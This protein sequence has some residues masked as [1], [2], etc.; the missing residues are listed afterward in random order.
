MD[1]SSQIALAFPRGAHQEAL[2]E[3]VFRYVGEHGLAWT[4]AV[5]PESLSLS[6]TDLVDW[7]GDGVLAAIDT[8]EQAEVA[9]SLTMPVVNISSSLPESPSPR[10]MVDNR[11]VGQVAAEHLLAKGQTA[12][13]FYGLEG[14]EYSK[15]RWKGFEARLEEA[16]V[17]GTQHLAAP[18]YSF[19]GDRWKQQLDEL[20]AW[21]TTLPQP[22]GVFAVSDY[23]SRLVLDAA[24]QAG[25][26]SPRQLAI[27]GVDNE[28]IICE[29]C[30]P[31]LSSVV[32]NNTLEGY[33]AA[34]M[35]HR[36]L[37]GEAPD[38]FEQ[39][40][41][42]LGVVERESTMEYAVSDPRLK[43]ALEYIA[44]RSSEPITI[45]ELTEQLEVSRRWL[46]YAFRESL[47][48]SPYQYLQRQRLM[49]AKKLLSE[50]PEEKILTVARRAGFSSE[51][52]LR[53]AFQKAFG[54]TPGEFRKLTP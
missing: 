42:P 18:T 45:D 20:S 44:E 17:T 46:E 4:F 40:I 49:H 3:G 14:I 2:I 7:S 41:P 1:P 8:A 32:R 10:T 24:R 47:H 38:P 51:K 28:H 31:T 22:C 6:I 15:Q 12:F 50:E 33:R 13:A 30:S 37:E 25:I 34:A 54:M 53:L 48:E 21:L 9:R 5:A 23:R 16:G 35:L 43:S 11:A 27:L 52:Q 39:A 36:M 19:R 29:H 26:N